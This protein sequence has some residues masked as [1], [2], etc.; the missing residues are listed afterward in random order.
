M[1]KPSAFRRGNDA[2]ARTAERLGFTEQPINFICECDDE[3][4]FEEVPLT[5]EEYH[6]LRGES[7][8][9]AAGHVIARG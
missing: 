4:C 1:A 2:I 7:P 8:V 5:L 3:S 9:A 6:R